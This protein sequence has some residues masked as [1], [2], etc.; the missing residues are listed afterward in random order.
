MKQINWQLVTSNPELASMYAIE[1]CNRF[2]ILSEPD[3]DID[4]QYQNIITV[5]ENEI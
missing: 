1:V 5:E 4:K 3:D 2:E